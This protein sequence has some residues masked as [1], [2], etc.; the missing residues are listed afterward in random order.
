MATLATSIIIYGFAQVVT[1][2]NLVSVQTERFSTLGLGNAWGINYPIFIWFGFALACGFLLSRTTFGRYAYAVGGNAEAARL[3]GV[4]VNVIRTATFAISGLAAGIAGVILFS[5]VSTAQWNANSGI[6]FDAIT[7]IVLGG[8]SLF[9]G[10]GAIWRTVLGAFFLRDDRQRLRPARDDAPMAIRDQGP[11]PGRRRFTR[12]LGEAE[13]SVTV[14]SVLRLPVRP[15]SED[16]LVHAFADLEIFGHSERSG[17]FL[18]GRLLRPLGGGPFLVVAEWESDDAYRGWLENPIREELGSADRAAAHRRSPGRRAVRG[19]V[20]RSPAS[21]QRAARRSARRPTSA[22][23]SRISCTSSPTPRPGRSRSS[24]RSPR[25]RRRTSSVGVMN[26]MAK[27]GVQFGELAFIAHGTT[28]VI[29]ALTERK[30]VKTALITTEGFRDSLEIARGNRPDYFN[31]DYEKP[32]PF[33]PRYLR[34]EVPGRITHLG[35]E[36][37]P[38]DL[39]GLPAIVAAFRADGVEAVAICLLNAYVDPTRRAGGAPRAARALAGCLGRRLAPDHPRVAGV[40]ANQHG[41]PVRVR[42]AGRRALPQPSLGR[43]P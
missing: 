13:A 29:N 28:V 37:Q 25:R 7:A 9:G 14:V 33:V 40:R 21:R 39:D 3:S 17:G 19:R 31:L 27:G 8:T 6:E 12:R 32:P 36:R 20:G 34:R 30:G 38:L 23:P 5:E 1:S 15:G 42:A 11:D 4:R 24:R 22:A 41:R 16:A 35:V 18:G 2:G 26:V 10:E 43:H